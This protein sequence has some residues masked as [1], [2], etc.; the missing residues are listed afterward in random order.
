MS[1]GELNS[2]ISGVG[3]YRALID[4]DC[5]D[6]ELLAL[7]NYLT[8]ESKL[9]K[10]LENQSLLKTPIVRNGRL[11]TVGFAPEIWKNWD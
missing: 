11:A 3:G 1:R 8:E 6:R 9:D 2:V 10:L 4:E 7:F 5:R